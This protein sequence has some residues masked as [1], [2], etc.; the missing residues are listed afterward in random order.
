MPA[1]RKE[2]DQPSSSKPK[3]R[4]PDVAARHAAHKGTSLSA[5][6]CKLNSWYRGPCREEAKACLSGL[7]KDVTQ[8]T[9]EAWLAA[10]KYVL[11]IQDDEL[12]A[13]GSG[14][15]ARRRAIDRIGRLDQIFYRYGPHSPPATYHVPGKRAFCCQSQNYTPTSCRLAMTLTRRAGAFV[16][17]A[18]GEAVCSRWPED[19]RTSLTEYRRLQDSARTSQGG[20]GTYQP[21][22]KDYLASGT[23][24]RFTCSTSRCISRLESTLPPTETGRS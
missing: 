11:A 9:A 18:V 15:E 12:S 10:N 23:P 4:R 17:G 1:K 22:N 14:E 7:A 13:E 19:L 24:C 20:L 2:P 21:N 3:R 16:A 5:V 8:A 6:Q